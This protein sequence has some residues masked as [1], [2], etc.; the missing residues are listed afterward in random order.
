MGTCTT[1]NRKREIDHQREV[2][3]ETWQSKSMAVT[4]LFKLLTT[5]SFA[6]F[7]AT[8]SIMARFTNHLLQTKGKLSTPI[9]SIPK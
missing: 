1:D 2:G 3:Q 6:F 5:F 9:C 4:L 7:P 8:S